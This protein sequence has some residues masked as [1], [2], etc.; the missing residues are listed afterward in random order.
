MEAEP[1]VLEMEKLRAV[2]KAYM[3]M[4]TSLD[5]LKTQILSM[6]ERKES[7]TTHSFGLENWD[8]DLPFMGEFGGDC[9]EQ[10]GDD[11]RSEIN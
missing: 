5:M 10:I 3:V 4:V 1:K 6:R 11:R 2:D 8:G 9:I 7:K